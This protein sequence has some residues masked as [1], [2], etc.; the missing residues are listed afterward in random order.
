MSAGASDMI[1]KVIAAI[2]AGPNDGV[3][4]PIP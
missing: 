3:M 1:G 2:I 4:V